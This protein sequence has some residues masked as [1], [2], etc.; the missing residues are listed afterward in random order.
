MHLGLPVVALSAATLLASCAALPVAPTTVAAGHQSATSPGASARSSPT[1]GSG[2]ALRL[3]ASLPVKGRAPKTGYTRE[4]FGQAWLDADRNGCDTRNDILRRDLE[5]TRIRPGTHGCLVESGTLADPYTATRI[6]F[7]RGTTS[8]DIDHV[9]ALSD[10]WQTGAFRWATTKRAALANDPL[11]LLAVDYSANRQKGDGDLATWMPPNRRYRCAYA[12]RQVAVKAKYRL[13]VTPAEHATMVRVLDGC[14]GQRVPTGAAPTVV[15][16][17]AGAPRPGSSAAPASGGV[18]Y[19]SCADVRA[20]GA[21]PIR[22][23]DPGYA[24]HLDRDGDG[25]GCE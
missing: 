22:R 10:A 11:N 16:F 20:A 3:L 5:N 17:A 21:A 12:A 18:H 9:V 13:W 23:G 7:V 2:N 4:A 14:P 24:A 1:T 15:R 25:I 8:V 19:D 6:S